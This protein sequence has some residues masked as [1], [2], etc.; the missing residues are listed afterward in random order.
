MTFRTENVAVTRIAK[1]LPQIIAGF[2][3]TL[4]AISDGMTFAWTS[5]MTIYLTSKE[6][7]IRTTKEVVEWLE[8]AFLCGC[9][10]GIPITLYT[11]DKFGRKKSLVLVSVMMLVGWILIGLANRMIYIFAARVL[12]GIASNMVYVACPMYNAEIADEKIRGFLSA[13]MMVMDHTGSLIIYAIG[14][15]TPFYT[16]PLLGSVIVIFQII[17]FSFMPDSPFYLISSGKIADAHKALT[18]FKPYKDADDEINVI[19]SSIE[20]EKSEKGQKLS[21]FDTKVNRKVLTIITVLNLTPQMLGYPVIIMNLHIILKAAGSIYMDF[22]L[23]AI[24]AG[25]IMLAATIF[26]SVSVDRFGRRILLLVSST[27][28]GCCVL[29][30]A[31]YFHLQALSYNT[32]PVSWIPIVSVFI[33]CLFFKIGIGIV[34]LIVNAEIAPGNIKAIAVT[35]GDGLKIVGSIISVQIYQFVTKATGLYLPFYIYSCSAVV[36]GIFT[37]FWIP[38]TKGHSLEEIQKILKSD[39]IGKR[40]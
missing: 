22:S 34:P 26:C 23:A 31:V 33:F 27:V 28:S 40:Y 11:V 19:S 32:I 14:P 2:A 37:F 21:I 1:F 9:F 16:A 7:H 18:F 24:T 4:L 30:L 36:L 38:E 8:T 3:G 5:P 20:S 39:S 17:V 25:S 12:A 35:Y 15:Y 6:S 29:A 13:I 10:C